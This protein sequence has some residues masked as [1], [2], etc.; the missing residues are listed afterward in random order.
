MGEPEFITSASI[1]D[2]GIIEIRTKGPASHESLKKNTNLM[3][4]LGTKL[5]AQR[6][7]I[8]ILIDGTG[9]TSQNLDSRQA[10]IE[11]MKK[12]PHKKIAFFGPA[13]LMGVV[14]TLA[15]LA[16]KEDSIRTFDT[17]EVATKWLLEQ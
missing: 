16:G 5:A 3:I 6:K 7:P 15:V 17:E 11:T 1:N 14:D 9:I 2:L 12:L 4:K 10:M 8:L 13:L